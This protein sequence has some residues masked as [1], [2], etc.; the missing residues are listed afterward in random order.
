MYRILEKL[1]H[2]KLDKWTLL[3]FFVS[4]ILRYLRMILHLF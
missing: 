4:D 3:R 1:C 2:R